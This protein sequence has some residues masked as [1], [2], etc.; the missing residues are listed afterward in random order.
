[1]KELGEKKQEG[2]SGKTN[3]IVGRTVGIRYGK[4]SRGCSRPAEKRG[5][6]GGTG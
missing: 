5:R 1:V 4:S 6:R 3:W 2:E